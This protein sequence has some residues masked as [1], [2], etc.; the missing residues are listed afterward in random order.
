MRA[1]W[2]VCSARDG[3]CPVM[4]IAPVRLI[5]WCAISGL[6]LRGS[7]ATTGWRVWSLPASRRSQGD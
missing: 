6:V 2:L 1:S 7:R 3:T 4:A 5:A